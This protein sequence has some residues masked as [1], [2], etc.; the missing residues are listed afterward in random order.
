[1][2][3]SEWFQ[4]ELQNALIAYS[5]DE[6]TLKEALCGGEKDKWW[7]AIE[8]ELRQIEDLHT[9]DLVEAPSD[10]N[11]IPLMF[12]FCWKRNEEG[13]IIC[14]KARLVAKGYKQKFGI[15]YNETFAPTV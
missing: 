13:L 6:P 10:A 9:Y 4:E 3:E 12:V 14:Y 1:M 7:E 8:A 2:N 5:E 11:I 15:N